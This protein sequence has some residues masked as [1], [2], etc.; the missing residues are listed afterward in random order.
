MSVTMT[1]KKKAEK[2]R[3][4]GM[5]G[6]QRV[7]DG[8]YFS[9][10]NDYSPKNEH[11]VY[12]GKCINIP[13]PK[14]TK[15]T[16]EIEVA[17]IPGRAETWACHRFLKG[18]DF[19][20]SGPID[21][22]TKRYMTRGEAIAAKVDESIIE[23]KSNMKSSTSSAKRTGLRQAIEAVEKYKTSLYVTPVEEMPKNPSDMV[24]DI[25]IVGLPSAPKHFLGSAYV[26]LRESGGW[27]RSGYRILGT[28]DDVGT[29]CCEI[30]DES[31][32]DSSRDTAIADAADAAAQY[33]YELWMKAKGDK[34]RS[35]LAALQQSFEE[36]C[37][38]HMGAVNSTD[39][40]AKNAKPT[41][42][43][44]NKKSALEEIFPSGP[45]AGPKKPGTSLVPAGGGAI[46]AGNFTGLGL[47]PV[48]DLTV[49]EKKKLEKCELAI[50]RNLHSWFELGAALA[51]ISNDRL[52]RETHLTFQQYCEDRFE[53]TRQHAY[54]LIDDYTAVK[55]LSPI[56]D[57]KILP[58]TES[59]ARVLAKIKDPEKRQEVWDQVVSAAA[60]SDKP[61]IT[62]EAIEKTKAE[63]LGEPKTTAAKKEP[64]FNTTLPKGSSDLDRDKAEL[65]AAV[66]KIIARWNGSG[67]GHNALCDHLKEL[68]KRLRAK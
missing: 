25:E 62:A 23:L 29:K 7:D 65:E 9:T 36:L 32:L 63:V 66:K 45:I 11:G 55:E 17:R 42:K 35:L 48:G 68:A 31:N 54:R 4:R 5:K 60:A 2:P 37:D 51:T 24:G 21:D 50:E 43:P 33:V 52:Y 20:T 18:P 12:Q 8:D 47:G 10:E 56:G 59:Q 64:R 41:K 53:F 28:S 15:I 26:I 22:R 34:K 61:N 57:K 19:Y 38:K 58:A 16:V 1:N 13:I 44:A 46:V 3:K 30:N 67:L 39:T 6:V 14:S 49:I 27:W 40:T